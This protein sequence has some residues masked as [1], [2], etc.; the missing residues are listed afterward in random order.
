V[1]YLLCND[2]GPSESA[3][4]LL[5]ASHCVSEAGE[6]VWTEGESLELVGYEAMF[7]GT[8]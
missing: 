1:N 3:V 2:T 7:C 6:Q 4:A 8:S 5:A